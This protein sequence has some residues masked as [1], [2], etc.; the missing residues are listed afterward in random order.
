MEWTSQVEDMGVYGYALTYFNEWFL[1][2]G[3]G[4]GFCS[5]TGTGWSPCFA[6][7]EGAGYGITITD[8][9]LVAVGSGG[10]IYTSPD[11]WDWT[12]HTSS[13][14][15]GPLMGVAFGDEGFLAVSEFTLG[16]PANGILA[17]PDGSSWRFVMDRYEDLWSIIHANSLYVAVGGE[18]FQST[19]LTSPDGETFTPATVSGDAPLLDVTM[20]A[21]QFVAV[22]EGGLVVTS[23]DGN[24]WT[25]QTSGTTRDLT[26]VAYGDGTYVAVGFGA[27]I[28]SSPDGVTWASPD[29]DTTYYLSTVA[30]GVGTFVAAGSSG[31]L[32]SPDGAV[33]TPLALEVPA[34]FV[35]V[36]YE[37]DRF[38]GVGK[39]GAIQTS[40]DG[41]AWTA[42]NC[43]VAHDLNAVAFGLDRFVVVGGMDHRFV[44]TILQSGTLNG[45][46]VAPVLSC[47]RGVSAEELRLTILGEPGQSYGIQV[48]A[49]LPGDWQALEDVVATNAAHVITRAIDPGQPQQFYR[50]VQNP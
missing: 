33:W 1:G 2:V 20:G 7:V 9:G 32:T 25:T 42:R 22:G 37:A 19:I 44:P 31:V 45:N 17:S 27:S 16:G 8:S 40:P 38:I 3:A 15:S 48:A 43:G 46:A 21:D 10:A 13:V 36:T 41:F 14:G 12:P 29:P 26:G 49:G 34:W 28:L 11:G 23:P 47:E 24:A 6:F 50:A 5:Q 35:D 4:G 30:H 39:S 18:S